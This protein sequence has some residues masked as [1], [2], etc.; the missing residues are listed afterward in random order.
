[1]FFLGCRIFP[2]AV[3]Y[4]K[5]TTL[6][7]YYTNGMSLSFWKSYQHISFMLPTIDNILLLDYFCMTGIRFVITLQSKNFSL[8]A[9]L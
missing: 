3:F 1:M 8:R 6:Y 2:A 7:I 5:N 9:I 4:L